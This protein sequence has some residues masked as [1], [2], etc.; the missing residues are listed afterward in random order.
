P[1]RAC[2]ENVESKDAGPVLTTGVE[3]IVVDVAGRE[4]EGGEKV[5][6]EA[7]ADRVTLDYSDYELSSADAV[8]SD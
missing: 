2:D 5:G 1:G 7:A 8:T 3:V 4:G 6:D